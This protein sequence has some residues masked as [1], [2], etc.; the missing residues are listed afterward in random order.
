MN[1]P[2]VPTVDRDMHLGSRVHWRSYPWLKGT[3][4]A[5]L[6]EAVLVEWDDG[7]VGKTT[8]DNIVLEPSCGG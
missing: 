3:V 7:G 8:V 5:L 6:D 4:T 1:K 2:V